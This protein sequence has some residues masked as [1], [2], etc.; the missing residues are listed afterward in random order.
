LH[1]IQNRLQYKKL[2][3]QVNS[4][5]TNYIIG[6]NQTPVSHNETARLKTGNLS[7]PGLLFFAAL[8][9]LKTVL[10]LYSILQWTGSAKKRH[11]P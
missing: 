5:L 8:K 9:H 7:N 11:R 2:L 10:L 6:Y 1:C 4:T 3:L